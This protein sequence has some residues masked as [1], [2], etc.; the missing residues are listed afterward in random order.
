MPSERKS[1]A[2]A[3]PSSGDEPVKKSSKQ[4]E[5]KERKKDK[6]RGRSPSSDDLSSVLSSPRAMAVD[7]ASGSVP[8]VSN[9]AI[10]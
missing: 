6:N 5:R 10:F 3:K 1:G 9:A 4:D 7:N 8:D 2:R